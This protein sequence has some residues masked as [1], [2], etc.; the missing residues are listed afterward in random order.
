LKA[1]QMLITKQ[2]MIICKKHFNQWG[3]IMKFKM[4]CSPIL[5]L[6]AFISLL[7]QFGCDITCDET[8]FKKSSEKKKYAWV[9]GPADSTNYG[10]ILFTPDGGDTW[11]R[12]GVGSS[13]LLNVDL[14]D[15]WAIDTNVI[16]V[17][18]SNNSVIKTS[19]G[20]NTWLRLNDFSK[21]INKLLFSIAIVG[22]TNIWISGEEA[23]VY[24]STNGGLSWNTFN[25]ENFDSAALQGIYPVSSEIIYSVG[26]IQ[27]GRGYIT[28]TTDG[29]STWNELIPTDDYNKHR[30][31]GVKS[32]GLNH[33]VIFGGA[34]HYM[35]SSD[36]GAT[37]RND[38]IPGTGGGGTGGADINCLTMLDENTWWTALDYDGI[39]F[40]TDAGASWTKQTA[41]PPACMWLFGIDYYDRNNAIIVGRSSM[42]FFGKIIITSDGGNTWDLKYTIKS[43]L[44]KV[45]FVKN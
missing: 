4:S 6:I 20:G 15:V 32:C 12:K 5:I 27:N 24:N 9:V 45:S 8:E 21:S 2:C 40:T 19:D 43:R 13:A 11:Q 7:I 23:T 35:Y 28:R 18:G 44:S 1:F 17:V 31:I 29:G 10:V 16:W 33:I 38:S 22:Y 3:L 14:N 34:S 39:T 37:W 42:S 25:P 26:G 41:P 36:G 30:W